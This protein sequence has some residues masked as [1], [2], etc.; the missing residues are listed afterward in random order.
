MDASFGD[1]LNKSTHLNA[2]AKPFVSRGTL[3]SEAEPSLKRVTVQGVSWDSQSSSVDCISAPLAL[4]LCTLH[5]HEY[6]N[7]NVTLVPHKV[8]FN[9]S[10]LH[11]N[12]SWKS[13][14]SFPVQN[15]NLFRLCSYAEDAFWWRRVFERAIE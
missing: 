12:T 9:H 10:N 4:N 7:F 3:P 6:V 13:E 2:N 8:F 11:I 1:T 5:A 14:N 15:Q